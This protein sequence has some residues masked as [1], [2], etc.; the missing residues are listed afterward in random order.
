[1]GNRQ[2]QDCAFLEERGGG[3]KLDPGNIMNSEILKKIFYEWVCLV[4]T[5]IG[6]LV[7]WHILPRVFSNHNYIDFYMRTGWN[8]GDFVF[9]ALI[10]SVY[11][12]RAI[13]WAIKRATK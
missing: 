4:F 7:V 9:I 1:M 12:I 3:F 13:L 2:P 5:V 6:A 10:I 11:L 8:L